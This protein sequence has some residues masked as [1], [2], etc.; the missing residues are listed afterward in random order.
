MAD[1]KPNYSRRAARGRTCG[2]RGP[3]ARCGCSVAAPPAESAA[4]DMV[5]GAVPR[6][7]RRT[8]RDAPRAPP[9]AGRRKDR[10]GEIATPRPR[11]F[12]LSPLRPSQCERTDKGSACCR[13]NTCPPAT[14]C[15]GR[16]AGRAP[17]Q[18]VRAPRRAAQRIEGAQTSLVRVAAGRDRP[19]GAAG[20]AA[21]A[22]AVRSWRAVGERASP[23]CSACMPI[24]SR[25]MSHV[26]L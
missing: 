21:A 7:H 14:P 16:A 3:R 24:S 13:P 4:G 11:R 15:N 6:R 23:A 18:A 2:R 20:S 19:G 22:T 25:S 1:A 12:S 9:T 17:H 10:E 26:L 8:G 5:E